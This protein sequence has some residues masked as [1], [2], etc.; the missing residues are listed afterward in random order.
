VIANE[1]VGGRA[2][3]EKIRERTSGQDDPEVLVVTPALTSSKLDHWTSDIDEAVA[4]AEQRLSRSLEVLDREGFDARGDVGDSDPN[5]AIS[6][7]LLEF[8]ASEVIIST[9]PPGRSHWLEQEVVERAR[10]EL[11]VPVTHVVVDLEAEA[12]T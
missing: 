6:D 2:L 7:A 1:T 5:I 12:T 11:D 10:E 3:L 9:H 8:G 4:A